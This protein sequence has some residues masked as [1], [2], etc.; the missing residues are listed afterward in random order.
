MA[1][2]PEPWKTLSSEFAK[3]RERLRQLENR[4]PFFGTGIHPNGNQ[5]LDSDNFVAGVSGYSFQGDTGNAEFNDLTLRGGIIGND[6]LTTPTAPGVV[7]ATASNFAVSTSYT[8]LIT[9]TVTVPPGFTSAAVSLTGRVFAIDPNTT[10]GSNGSGADYLYALTTI[11][12]I[13]GNG[14][15]IP[16]GGYNGSIINACPLSTILTGL[17]PGGTFTVSLSAASSFQAFA[18]DAS[19]T[20]DLGGSILWFR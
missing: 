18:A 9:R 6:A 12:G 19:N 15:P 3:V 1:Q 4:S 20:A 10:G 16:L 11:A 14:L 7:W 8:T 17:T 2:M 5:G 13:D